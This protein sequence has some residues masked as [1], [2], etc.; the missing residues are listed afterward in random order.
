M[1][2]LDRN[3][4]YALVNDTPELQV[5]RIG[6]RRRVVKTSFEEWYANQDTY[7]KFEEL[8][9][10][11]QMEMI[12]HCDDA[13]LKK[14]LIRAFEK[15]D[16]KERINQRAWYTVNET[17]ELLKTSNTSVFRMIR[18]GAILAT[19]DGKVWKI[20]KDEILW[21]LFQEHANNLET[22]E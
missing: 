17:A 1:I 20:S 3:Q 9:P 16:L 11:E 7:R 13:S 21:L 4:T 2:G 5:I 22:E 6:G 19:Q 15:A 12:N 10:K 18:S 14:K 8:S